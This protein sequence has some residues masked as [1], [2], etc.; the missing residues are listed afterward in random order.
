M[1]GLTAHERFEAQDGGVVLDSF[2]LEALKPGVETALNWD[3]REA[4][5]RANPV[6]GEGTFSQWREAWMSSNG[7]TQH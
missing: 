3:M 1:A 4:V 6:F 2:R 5:R 7:A